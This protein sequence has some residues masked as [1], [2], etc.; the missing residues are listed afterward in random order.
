MCTL[1]IFRVLQPCFFF[2]FNYNKSNKGAD[3]MKNNEPPQNASE[4]LKR[5][6]KSVP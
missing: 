5:K 4:L 2:L 6:E 3:E 1:D